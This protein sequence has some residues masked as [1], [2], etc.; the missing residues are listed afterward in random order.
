MTKK[1]LLFALLWS[2]I[3]SIRGQENQV[4][5]WLIYI[6]NKELKNSL[7]W[8][9]EIQHRNYNFFWRIRTITS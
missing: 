6:G 7:N 5:N 8:H 1:I 4:G 2:N 3:F 9:H